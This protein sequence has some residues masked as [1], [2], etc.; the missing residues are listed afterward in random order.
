MSAVSTET[1]KSA[2]VIRLN[3]NCNKAPIAQSGMLEVRLADT[4]EDVLACQRL[5]YEVFYE[6]MTAKP[7]ADMAATRLDHDK[8]DAIAD[9][10]MVIEKSSPENPRVV[11]TYRLIRREIAEANGGF[12]TAGEYD[13]QALLDRTDPSVNF[14]ELG[15]SCVHADYRTKPTINMLWTGLGH[16]VTQNNVGVL[17]GCASFPG[18]DPSALKLPLSFL[19]HHVRA[20]DQ[21]LVR[22]R[23]ELFEEMNL[24]AKEEIDQKT[25]LR[26]LPPLIRGYMRAG[27][28]FG[29]GAVIDHQFSTTDVFVMS[30]IQDVTDRYSSRF[31]V[32]K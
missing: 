24:M 30:V 3:A 4:Q 20:P 27:C 32:V 8:F 9:H 28:Y 29:D 26:A 16:Y 1:G 13:I 14:L 18:I 15:R 23:E 7:I 22:A 12:Y 6:E 11:G 10:L 31:G 5:R 19:Y 17:F 21:W 25:A 2:T